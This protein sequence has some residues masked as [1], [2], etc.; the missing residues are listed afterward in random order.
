MR[1]ILPRVW[2]AVVAVAVATLSVT[3]ASPAGG[4]PRYLDQKASIHARVNDPGSER[5]RGPVCG[6]VT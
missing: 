2:M 1:R 4:S 5:S 6:N 3:A